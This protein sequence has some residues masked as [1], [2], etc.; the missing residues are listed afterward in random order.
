M[1]LWQRLRVVH[2]AWRYRL[3]CEPQE[4]A[5]VRTQLSAGDTAIDIGAHQGAFTYWMR[6]A[7]G[8]RGRVIAFEPQP[9][10]ATFLQSTKQAFRMR[11]VTIVNAGLSAEPGQLT[12]RR[13]G[14][15]PSACATLE[16][17]GWDGGESFTVPVATLDRY[18]AEQQLR[19]INFIKCDV[20]GH[21]LPVFHGAATILREDRPVL[22]FECEERMHAGGTMQDVFDFLLGLGYEGAFFRNN[23]QLPLDEFRPEYQQPGMPRNE[24]ANNFVFLPRES[25][26]ARQQRAA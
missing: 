23:R 1:N 2:R 26:S 15:A 14:N 21:E 9:E 17:G 18:C 25:Q 7:V 19:P 8:P 3:R 13:P 16:P 6:K 4:I 20:E 24:Y 12:M 22:L 11:N 5:F 10:M